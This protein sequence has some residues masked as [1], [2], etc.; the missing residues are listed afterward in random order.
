[1]EKTIITGGYILQPRKIDESDVSKMPPVTR[2][3]WF[4]LLR[5]VN[6]KNFGKLKRGQGFF[7]F[8]QIQKD[9][10]WMVGYRI[11]KYSKPQLTKSLRRLNEGN[12]T[13]TMKA[14]HGMVITVCNYDYYQN[15]ENYEGNDEGSTKE[16]R[17]KRKG[18]NIYKNDKNEECKNLFKENFFEILKIFYFKN[19]KNPEKVANTFFNHY[20]KIGWKD[21]NGNNIENPIAA[22]ENWENKTTEG[23][24]CPS[25][26]LK[27]WKDV[28]ELCKETIPEYHFLLSIRPTQIN[29][30]TLIING[31][32]QN[33]TKIE[34]DANLRKEFK[35]ALVAVFGKINV[36]YQVDN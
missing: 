16:T 10:S 33:I 29:G 7:K 6:H 23:K 18:H 13:E 22:A 9:L 8:S 2:E 12:M 31:N 34:D 11:E 3:L 30:M 36:E 27:K 17:R 14:T 26:L 19:Y 25:V 20:D 35:K 15:P 21:K 5:K 28:Y 32:Q 24:N 4:Y 1:M